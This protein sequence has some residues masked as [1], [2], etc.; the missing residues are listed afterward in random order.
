M[1]LD[2]CAFDCVSLCTGI[3]IA[4]GTSSE[5]CSSTGSEAGN[6]DSST[7]S[8]AGNGEKSEKVSKKAREKVA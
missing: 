6:G 5:W 2:F 4:K 7:G 1:K 8:E 3:Y